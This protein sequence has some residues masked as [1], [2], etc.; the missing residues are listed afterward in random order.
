MRTRAL[1]YTSYATFRA[2]KQAALAA[3]AALV[4]GLQAGAGRC[5]C[6]EV[7]RYGT[8]GTSNAWWHCIRCHE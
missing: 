6:G 8:L 5:A 1:R 7:L 3:V 4:D 2:I